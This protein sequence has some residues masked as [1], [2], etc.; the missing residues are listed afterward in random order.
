MKLRIRG[1]SIRLRLEQQE[2]RQLAH[3]GVVE[4]I[5]SFPASASFKYSLRLHQSDQFEARFE[6]GTIAVFVPNEK[7]KTW[8]ASDDVGI[9]AEIPSGDAGLKIAIEKDFQCLHKRPDEDESDM[10]VNP[11]KKGV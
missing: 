4:E 5:V 9:Y 1:N 3:T 10:F 7:G 2:V 6:Q 8:A 11:L